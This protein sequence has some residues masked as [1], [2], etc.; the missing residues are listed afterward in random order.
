MIGDAIVD[1]FARSLCAAH[2]H[3]W[4]SHVEHP[5]MRYA[6]RFYCRRCLRNRLEFQWGEVREFSAQDVE[7]LAPAW[8]EALYE[9]RWGEP[10][11]QRVDSGG[12]FP[13]EWGW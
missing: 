5:T 3:R 9:A 13:T 2:E 4:L 8:L 1:A 10:P 7:R 11:R 6:R 12:R